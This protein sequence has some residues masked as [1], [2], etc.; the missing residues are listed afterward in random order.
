MLDELQNLS[1]NPEGKSSSKISRKIICRYGRGCTHKFDPMH[2]ERF[3]HP[4]VPD[5]NVEQ[6]RT[7]YICY[8]CAETFLHLT[9]LQV[10]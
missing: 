8:E 2:R 9:D 6:I 5:L 1:I 4:E 10:K 7:H 3:W